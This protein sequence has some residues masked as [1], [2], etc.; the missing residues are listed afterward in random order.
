MKSPT[1]GWE[2]VGSCSVPFSSSKNAAWSVIS[3]SG[4]VRS[5]PKTTYSETRWIRFASTTSLGRY[6][7]VSDTTATPTAAQ[8]TGETKREQRGN[9]RQGKGGGTPPRARRGD[10]AAA[11]VAPRRG[12]GHDLG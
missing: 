3:A 7:V 4:T 12:R 5:P 11:R 9:D 1:D 2:V 6:E 8:P 10:R